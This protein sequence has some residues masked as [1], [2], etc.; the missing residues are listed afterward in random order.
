MCWTCRQVR[1]SRRIHWWRL[2]LRSQR[3]TRVRRTIQR[4]VWR[5]L[6]RLSRRAGARHWLHSWSHGMPRAAHQGQTEPTYC[7]VNILSVHVMY[8]WIA[9]WWLKYTFDHKL[10]TTTVQMHI[11]NNN[12]LIIIIIIIII[13]K[14]CRAPYVKIYVLY[15]LK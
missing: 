5:P 12:I 7:R 10:D 13:I 4:A 11:D 2:R 14:T 3:V 1:V 6:Q 15:Y 9:V 8:W